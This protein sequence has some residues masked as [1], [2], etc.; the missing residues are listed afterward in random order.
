[1]KLFALLVICILAFQV[2]QSA[3]APEM[4]DSPAEAQALRKRAS[5]MTDRWSRESLLAAAQMYSTLSKYFR[6]IELD[7]L[8]A[9][10]ADLEQARTLLILGDKLSSKALIERTL[11]DARPNQRSLWIIANCEKLLIGLSEGKPTNGTLSDLA[12]ERLVDSTATGMIMFVRAEMAYF[13]HDIKKSIEFYQAA[14]QNVS[15]IDPDLSSRFKLELG[16]AHLAASNFDNALEIF[17]ELVDESAARGKL[18]VRALSLIGLGHVYSQINEK[19]AALNAYQEAETNF[20]D[21]V[22]L[23]D[24]AKLY[25]GLGRIFEEFGQLQTAL[26]QRKRAYDSLTRIGHLQGQAYTLINL[27]VLSHKL[28]DQD[29]GMIYFDSALR[30]FD[31][32]GDSTGRAIVHAE[33][34]GLNLRLKNLQQAAANYHKSQEFF[35]KDGQGYMA[36]SIRSGLAL[37]LFERGEL[38]AAKTEFHRIRD[39]Q[40]QIRDTAGEADTLYQIARVERFLGNKDAAIDAIH[41]SLELTESLSADVSNTQLRRSFISTVF[42]RYELYISLL[43]AHHDGNENSTV[44]LDIAERSRSRSILE[45]LRSMGAPR[46]DVPADLV[47]RE[48]SLLAMLGAKADELTT[49]LGS[50]AGSAETQPLEAEIQE[51][52]VRLEEIRAKMRS[53]E[54]VGPAAYDNYAFDLNK[55]QS[56]SL[57]NE[58]VLIQYHLG[59]EVSLLWLVSKD[60]KSTH[61]LPPKTSIQRYIEDLVD[62]IQ[63]RRATDNE[64]LEQRQQRIADADAKYAVAARE[65]SEMI[66]GPVA[67]KIK[68]KR[69]IV[70]PDGKLNYF[71]ISALPMPG[72]ESDDPILLT[73]EV[74]YQPSAQTYALLK[75]IGQERKEE[76]SKDL[77]VFSDPVFNP[78]DERLTGIA[79][80]QTSNEPYRYRLVESFSS[81][82]R[83]PASKTEAETVSNAVGSSDLFMGFDATRERLLSTNLAHYRVVHLATHGFLDPERPELSSLVLSRFDQ[84]GKQID[85]SIRMHDIYSMRLNA[86]LVVLSACQT[87]TGKEIKGEGVMGLNTA[88]LQSGARS[89]VSTLWQVEDNAANE[90]MKE[91]YGKMV[92]E[93]MSPSA[94]LRAAQIKLYND[95]QFRSPFFWAA[96]TVHGDAAS[97]TPFK[98]DHTRL[99]I[100]LGSLAVLGL[101]AFFYFLRRYRTSKV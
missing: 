62:S 56:E 74:I 27:A 44:G 32:A 80:V 26:T 30:L 49:R 1:M 18:R 47:S 16:F 61:A 9:A 84:T 5:E 38:G 20:P 37:V 52:R 10:E 22:D 73:N 83:L 7:T 90:L 4:P 57:G 25:N 55:F 94:A 15:S 93:G 69:L 21:D 99:L 88:F 6:E 92:D 77:L 54:L 71:P 91:F 31:A 68:G 29:Q 82:S 63:A 100:G 23:F 13:D 50:G 89:V 12:R 3:D 14:V 76:T 24:R 46:R 19:R 58:E 11:K 51:V 87:G 43:T 101:V 42:D 81:L 97:S 70:V 95:P 28:G 34:G 66:L 65:L 96:F 67:E 78:A 59:T 85:E 60:Q 39:L 40:K 41:Q 8:R 2:T 48:K 86:D 98:K 64:S 79:T 33:L 35:S 36:S 53:N 17:H 72:S 75:K 45:S